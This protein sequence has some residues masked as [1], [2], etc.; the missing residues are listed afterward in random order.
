MISLL[1]DQF[2]LPCVKINIQIQ[3]PDQTLISSVSVRCAC[4]LSEAGCESDA[5]IARPHISG[6]FFCVLQDL[7]LSRAKLYSR[8][9]F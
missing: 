4:L 2:M 5:F 8:R 9:F 1:V 3:Y 6:T 7:P